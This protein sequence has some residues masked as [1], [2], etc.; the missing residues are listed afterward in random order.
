M[1]IQVDKGVSRRSV[2][3]QADFVEVCLFCPFTTSDNENIIN[4]VAIS[5]RDVSTPRWP[6][7]IFRGRKRRELLFWD[8]VHVIIYGL[9]C[10]LRFYSLV[11][12]DVCKVVLVAWIPSQLINA[13]TTQPLEQFKQSYVMYVQWCWSENSSSLALFSYQT[14]SLLTY[15]DLKY[16]NMII[17]PLYS[18]IKSCTTGCPWPR[19]ASAT[20]ARFGESAAT[21]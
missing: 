5:R 9:L 18:I 3:S 19:Q 1:I 2:H 16:E 7:E 11:V 14:R 15:L 10:P 17:G 12:R 13:G 21:V 8:H 6:T 4:Y 20:N